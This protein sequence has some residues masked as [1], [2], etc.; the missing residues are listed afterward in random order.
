MS[1]FC[2]STD[3]SHGSKQAIFPYFKQNEKMS[4]IWQNDIPIPEY[5]ISFSLFKV[6]EP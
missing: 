4:D 3:E 2:V 1:S 6:S 5:Q